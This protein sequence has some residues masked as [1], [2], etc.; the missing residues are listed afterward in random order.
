MTVQDDG[1]G[2]NMAGISIPVT[3]TAVDDPPSVARNFQLVLPVGTTA[4]IGPNLLDMQDDDPN[5][6]L[7]Y[8]IAGHHAR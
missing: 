8:T 4:A 2:S 3:V 1:G 7:R 6:T 5:A